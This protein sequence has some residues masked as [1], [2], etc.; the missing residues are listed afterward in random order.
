M[1]QRIHRS[2]R[3][4]LVAGDGTSP[5]STVTYGAEGGMQ[6]SPFVIFRAIYNL[7]SK[8]AFPPVFMRLPNVAIREPLKTLGDSLFSEN[9]DTVFVWSAAIRFCAQYSKSPAA[10]PLRT[11]RSQAHMARND[12]F[13]CHAKPYGKKPCNSRISREIG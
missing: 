1:L 8:I 3:A 11:N 12:T 10:S 9:G 13:S 4:K 6:K 5:V 7:T 2:R